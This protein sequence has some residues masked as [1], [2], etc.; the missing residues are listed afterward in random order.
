MG[1][2]GASQNKSQKLVLNWHAATWLRVCQGAIVSEDLLSCRARSAPG[3][4]SH[5]EF[6]S[7]LFK[8]VLL[9]VGADPM[10]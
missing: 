4:S 1:G 10:G 6:Q 9:S 7:L 5:L 8:A 3:S 2:G